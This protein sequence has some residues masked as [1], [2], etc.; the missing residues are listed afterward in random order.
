MRQRAR[1]RAR[2]RRATVPSG[3]ARRSV[4]RSSQRSLRV[5]LSTIS[6]RLSLARNRRVDVRRHAYAT[7]VATAAHT[8]ACWSPGRA[9]VDGDDQH[10]RRVGAV[11]DQLRERRRGRRARPRHRAPG[12]PRPGRRTAGWRTAPRTRAVRAAAGT[13]RSRRRRCRR[14]RRSPREARTP[15]SKPFVSW[16]KHRSPHSATTGPSC[17]PATPTAVDTKPSM[18]FAPRFASTRRPARGRHAPLERAHRQARR[19]DER[20]TVGNRGRDITRDPA[21][22]RDVVVEHAIERAPSAVAPRRRHAAEP[23]RCTAGRVEQVRELDRARAAR[24]RRPARVRTPSCCGSSHASSGSTSTVGT[25][26]SHAFAILLVSGAP[27]RTNEIGPVRAREARRRAAAPRRSRSRAE[28]VRSCESGSART[29]QPDGAREPLGHRRDRRPRPSPRPRA[30]R[31]CARTSAASAGHVVGRRCR[32]ARSTVRIHGAPPARPGA[33][34]SGAPVGTSGSRNG[35]FR[36]TGPAGGPVACRD[37]AAR[38]RTPTCVRVRRVAR[39]PRAGPG[40][41]NHRTAPPNRW[42][43]SMVWPAPQSRSSAGRSAV[44]T[45]SGTRAW[46]AS[47]TAGCRFTAAVPDVQHTIAGRPVARP[48]PSAR[49]AAERSSSTTSTRSRPSRTSASVSGV[50]RLPGDTTA[51][52]T[53]HRT[54]SSTSVCANEVVTSRSLTAPQFPYELAAPACGARPR[55]HADGRVVARR[56]PGAWSESCEVVAIDVPDAR[57]V[58]RDRDLDRHAGQACGV[59]RLLDGRPPRAAA[60]ARPAR[61]RVRARARQLDRRHRRRNPAP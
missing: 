22:A 7:A 53:P 50:L 12:R 45:S 4:Q 11:G 26:S 52:V 24:R 36:C 55:L 17:A 16:S 35:R 14:R 30:P 60:G 49:N 8:R 18:P 54:H 23:R 28:P 10:T 6:T 38:E 27:T 46:C 43:W 1:P 44:H 57:H 37:R 51:A 42:V 31:G 13:R 3:S 19:N 41:W 40:S 61:A 32:A 58:R 34:S 48:M 59:R 21:F 5:A 25:P 15:P 2:R 20:A 47:T 9:A 29:G 56:A 33:S 39:E